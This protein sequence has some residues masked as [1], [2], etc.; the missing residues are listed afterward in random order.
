MDF[1]FGGPLLQVI[2]IELSGTGFED[3]EDIPPLP[4]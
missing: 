4:L 1:Y 3:T 2:K